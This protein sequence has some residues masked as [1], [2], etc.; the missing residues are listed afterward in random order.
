MCGIIGIVGQ[1]DV[2][3]RLLDGLQRLEYRGYDSAGVAV[4]S[5]STVHVRRAV[6]KLD[7]L[8]ELLH[9]TRPVGSVGI[10]H[11]RWATH[12]AATLENAHPH[13]VGG[14]SL[15]HNGIIE[16]HAALREEL[17][18]AGIVMRSQTDTE[19]VAA[20]LDLLLTAS[21]TIDQAFAALLARLV[22]SFSLAVVFAG[23][24]DLM[25]VARQGSPLAIGYG[26]SANGTPIEVFVG[27]DALALAPF[28]DQISYLDDGDWAVIRPGEVE[29]FDSTG[30]A[31]IRE[32]KR[33]DT[34]ALSVD[35][36]PWAHFM[37][38]E[39]EEQ[40]ESLQ[41]LLGR[42]VA[43]D[44]GTLKPFL[45]DIDFEQVDRIVM[46]GCGS[47]YYACHMAGYWLEELARVPVEIELASEYRYRNRPLT[48]RELVIA[49]SQSGETA[50]T[51]SAMAALSGRVRQR[52][53]V[54]NVAS[55]TLARE[56][57]AV[58]DI[59]AGP[60]IGVAST[61]AFL[62]QVLALLG[63]ALKAG[64][65]RGVLSQE[66]LHVGV[67]D[68]LQ[69]PRI[70]SET[71]RQAPQIDALANQLAQAS[72]IYFIGRGPQYSLSL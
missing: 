71:L 35:K 46:L 15:V 41:S 1:S 21:S 56:A 18:A 60:E 11:T 64:Q 4:L 51:V 55:S 23:Y 39:I 67:Q 70:L 69:I 25:F 10:G 28:T 48:G 26:A 43:A 38:K 45:P 30:R 62:G 37:R 6:G 31:V 36:S 68:L 53:A 17:N 24:P 29:I 34:S 65:M 5:G 12:G 3:P 13:T 7:N 9:E 27:S 22:G 57:D 61:K 49:V 2:V 50:D 19:V 8:R 54:V 33:I 20:L 16:N 40:P 14:V 42:L 59:C 58:L 72:D 63:V 52:L 32:V 47:A 66:R 44:T